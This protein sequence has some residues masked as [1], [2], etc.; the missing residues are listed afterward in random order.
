MRPS[1]PDVHI[2][3]SQDTEMAG[4]RALSGLAIAGLLLGI[5]TPLAL[6]TPWLWILPLAGLILSASGL[7]RI[8]RDPTALTGRKMAWT[9][10]LISLVVAV[11]APTDWLYYRW[12][13][14]NDARQFSSLWLR[15]LTHDEPHKAFQL[16]QRPQERRPLD[17][18]L[19]AY[20]RNDQKQQ[21]S[22]RTYVASPLVRTLLALGPRAVVR[23][24]D[25]VDQEEYDNGDLVSLT[26]AVTYE[27]EGEKKSFFITIESLR[28]N[29]GNGDAGWRIVGAA[30]AKPEG[31]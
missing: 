12:V 27:E 24:Y 19:W 17:D 1:V 20:Y 31:R 30:P 28:S 26:Y 11:A 23:F 14:R 5:V 29:A 9:G 10:L 6:L 8:A 2:T 18:S 13:L 15:C 25:T 22:L 4:Y 7:R 21:N 3:D 16:C